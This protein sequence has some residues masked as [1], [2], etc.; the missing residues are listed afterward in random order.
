MSFL[1]F[2]NTFAQLPVISIVE[3]E[4]T[5]PGFDR[6]ALT[7]WQKKGYIQKIR[8][9]YYRL[10]NPP[11][12]G[13]ADLFFIANRIYNPS[14]VSLQSALRW[15]DLIPEG[16]FTTTSVSTLKTMEFSS[17]VGQFS[18]RH[19]KPDLFWGYR[20]EPYG[21]YRIKIAD[22]A[23][24]LLDL[25]YLHPHLDSADDFFELRLNMFELREILDVD[26]FVRYLD[27][28]S[29]KSLNDR[30]RSFMKFLENHAFTF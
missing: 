23:K 25:F 16:V 4:K 22:P 15:H 12:K 10:S 3:I 2:Q 28:F 18:Y 17:A 30:A 7:R 9:G 13:D 24:A 5:F 20:L 11:L 8:R 1:E 14:Y 29:T 26:T 19:L 6:N 27:H 21:A